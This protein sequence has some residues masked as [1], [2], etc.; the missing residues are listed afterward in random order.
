MWKTLF[1]KSYLT[2]CEII[3][4]GGSHDIEC[5]KKF[6]WKS[7]FTLHIRELTVPEKSMGSLSSRIA[8]PYTSKNW[9]RKETPSV[10]R[11][12]PNSESEIAHKGENL[13]IMG[14]RG[15]SATAT[16]LYQK[17]HKA[18]K[19]CMNAMSA[20]RLSSRQNRALA[21][22]GPLRK[23]PLSNAKKCGKC[24]EGRNLPSSLEYCI[25]TQRKKCRETFTKKLQLTEQ[26][27]CL[28]NLGKF[29]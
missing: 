24:A 11:Q 21:A 19:R 18:E 14:M 23:K 12:I 3:H 1:T 22:R 13:R 28:N 25:E 17:C 16:L 2:K 5:G 27:Q 20:G 6:C 9:W 8:P 10:W 4:G 7:T 15:S 29:S 26:K